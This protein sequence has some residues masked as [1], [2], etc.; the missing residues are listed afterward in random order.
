[1]KEVMQ[2]RLRIFL[3]VFLLFVVFLAAVFILS[4]IEIES[5]LD[6]ARRDIEKEIVTMNEN[7]RED[8]LAYLA[9]EI[10]NFH[11]KISTLFSN[12]EFL[13]DLQKLYLPT[14]VNLKTNTWDNAATLLISHSWLD[15]V[16][17]IMDGKE[18]SFI[19]SEPP[20]L[21]NLVRVAVSTKLSVFVEKVAK[22]GEVRVYAAVPYWNNEILFRLEQTTNPDTLGLLPKSD[23]WLLF[24]IDT[25]MQIDPKTL[26]AQDLNLEVFP[27]SVPTIVHSSEGMKNLVQTTIDMI[28][29]TQEELRKHPNIEEEVRNS[30][31]VQKMLRM[32]A[33]FDK[34]L[35]K[36]VSQ[37]CH[38]SL[39]QIL[40]KR[41]NRDH[42]Q[43]LRYWER[44]SEQ[45]QL[46]WELAT[47]TGSGLWDF[48]PFAKFAPKGI[49]R[50]PWQD[51]KSYDAGEPAIG[52]FARTTSIFRQAPI[53]IQR[54][55]PYVEQESSSVSL[56]VNKRY[57]IVSSPK[58]N[59]IFL[60]GSMFFKMPVPPQ[61]EPRTSQLTLGI[62][63]D[64][65]LYRLAIVSP[66]N[67][68]MVT[69]N[70]IV[71]MY[72]SKGQVED[73]THNFPLPLTKAIQEK[74]GVI[75]DI[76][77]NEYYFIHLTSLTKNNG[78]SDGHVLVIERKGGEEAMMLKLRTYAHAL[79]RRISEQSAL[80]ALACLIVVLLIL[81]QVIKNITKPLRKLAKGAR[82]VGAGHFS[83]VEIPKKAKERGDEIG[84]L[85]F[86][87]SQ[88]IQEIQKGEEVRSLLDKVVSKEVA[89]KILSEGVKLGGEVRDVTIMFSDI[90]NFTQITEHMD[91]Q[92]VLHMLNDCLTILSRVIDDFSGVIDKYEG[93]EIMALFGAPL[94]MENQALTAVLCAIEMRE[95]LAVWNTQREA[96]GKCRLEIG[97][98]IHTGPG[99]AGNV[100]AENHLSYTVL[101]H[102]VNLAARICN[103]AEAMEILVTEEVINRPLVKEHVTY[104]PLEPVQ[105]KGVSQPVPLFRI[106]GKK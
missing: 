17:V 25:F 4:D 46:I 94:D 36:E 91:P 50:V 89:E 44:Q 63:L 80:I 105:F 59:S 95:V 48:D 70:G 56:C 65:M 101:G 88:M 85:C 86:A 92:D 35:E 32:D 38:E 16:Q 55:C 15:Y 3:W 71:R 14:N 11:E 27:K 79:M 24:D 22:T 98:G 39:C 81:N 66:N 69:N 29:F 62:S 87:F 78:M 43:R 21:E 72:T 2:I 67:L 5:Q 51:V 10:T 45:L 30:E 76:K 6:S 9:L 28:A 53:R 103:H 60:T 12:I 58:L 75:K 73:L 19:V 83:E 82:A 7:E 93:D 106:T 33:N 57:D 41:I 40:E 47:I 42:W 54:S 34:I 90:R 31:S 74:T 84:A 37:F 96:S 49:A 1:M 13:I 97:T 61:K 18:S 100:G 102:T 104:E 99:V 64:D 8:L 23:D 52:S 26:K 20:Y 77:G 68:M